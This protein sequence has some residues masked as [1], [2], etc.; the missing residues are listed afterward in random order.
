VAALVLVRQVFGLPDWL[1][2][3]LVLGVV[4]PAL[5]A[6]VLGLLLFSG[7]GVHGAYFAIATLAV[8]F[9]L[10]QGMTSSGAYLGGYNGIANLPFLRFGPLD[11]SG[12]A[13]FYWFAAALLVAI[14]A[15]LRG[16]LGS[17]LG[18]VIRGLREKEQRLEFLGYDTTRLK[19]WV[20][21][22]SAGLSGLAGT[23]YA[24]HGAFV[25]PQILGVEQSTVV[26]MW[27]AIGGPRTLLGPIVGTVLVNAGS[28]LLS[29]TFVD[30]WL[31]IV[32]VGLIVVI[33]LMPGGV[34]GLLLRSQPSRV[35]D[36]P[37]E[38]RGASLA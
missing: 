32:A 7:R 24:I 38:P 23:I 21:I 13:S 30:Q 11:V 36:T 20:F 10:E 17:R 16:L 19:L 33:R 22:A 27:V 9:L 2:L 3:A 18:L 26:V 5:M 1:A 37:G 15:A 31:L 35:Q 25:S 6:G 28:S 8:A 29:R 12:G 14:Y 34:V 4:V